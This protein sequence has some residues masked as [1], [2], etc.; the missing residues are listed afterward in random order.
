MALNLEDLFSEPPP[1]IKLSEN[2]SAPLQDRSSR[3]IFEAHFSLNNYETRP[4][5]IAENLCLPELK[6]ESKT[7]TAWRIANEKILA[8]NLPTVQ[9]V[10][11]GKIADSMISDGIAGITTKMPFSNK[12]KINK[13]G[14]KNRKH[15]SKCRLSAHKMEAALAKNAE[16]ETDFFGEA[17]APRPKIKTDDMLEQQIKECEEKLKNKAA[18]MPLR[19]KSGKEGEDKLKNKSAVM[20]F[21][22]KSGNPK[23]KENK[24]M[25][26]K[27]RKLPVAK[28]AVEVLTNGK[29]SLPLPDRRVSEP[30]KWP[31]IQRVANKSI[32][33][34]HGH[35][36]A[37]VLKTEL[38][39]LMSTEQN[40]SVDKISPS[41]SQTIPSI[42]DQII[43]GSTTLNK[44]NYSNCQ[45]KP[46]HN[47]NRVNTTVASSLNVTSRKE[48]DLLKVRMQNRVS[49]WPNQPLNCHQINDPKMPIPQEP[50]KKTI[51]PGSTENHVDGNRLP[52][53]SCDVREE[54]SKEMYKNEN[55]KPP[56]E[57][58]IKEIMKAHAVDEDSLSSKNNDE[59]VYDDLFVFF[60][61]QSEPRNIDR[62]END[63]SNQN[64]VRKKM[65][66]YSEEYSQ[67]PVSNSA[68]ESVRNCAIEEKRKEASLLELVGHAPLDMAVDCK[69]SLRT[70]FDHFFII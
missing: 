4:T 9:E 34:K 32:K 26:A 52:K 57:G 18:L 39:D 67:M 24:R 54:E 59:M 25:Q 33:I 41:G 17:E 45:A 60:E 2:N 23:T 35:H 55:S 38:K 61:D 56:G 48:T 44:N 66:I 30:H 36:S 51:V 53:I 62:N 46:M 21:N 49:R 5:Q 15:H 7:E 19:S 42:L 43:L 65:K 70:Q 14:N 37:T 47:L 3:P 16:D 8:L 27:K 22:G 63:R 10:S 64:N 29:D 12:K 28:D 58:P 20:P 1:K 50:A 68:N 31:V 69:V 6:Q 13:A 11:A 40:S